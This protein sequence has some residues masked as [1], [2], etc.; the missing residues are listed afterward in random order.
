M[1]NL[2][3]FWPDPCRAINKCHF[4]KTDDVTPII[5][6]GTFL[7][8]HSQNYWI[9]SKRLKMWPLKFND[10]SVLFQRSGL[11]IIL[12]PS[13]LVVVFFAGI[14]PGILSKLTPEA[15]YSS[16]CCVRRHVF[17]RSCITVA[18]I[19]AGNLLLLLIWLENVGVQYC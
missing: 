6:S 8:H 4:Q 12:Q 14:C 2:S 15:W 19:I 5:I 10:V 1:A 16:L 17:T 18:Q 9:S 11:S 13:W 7:F 3:T